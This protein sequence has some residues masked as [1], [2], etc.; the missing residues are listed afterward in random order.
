MGYGRPAVPGK[1]YQLAQGVAATSYEVQ[2]PEGDAQRIFLDAGKNP[3]DGVIVT[4]YLQQKP[5]EEVTLRFLDAQGQPIKAFSSKATN[6]Q[7]SAN[8]P[9][10]PRVPGEAGMNR[11][12]WNMRYADARGVPGDATTERSLT[13]PLARP[14]AYQVQLNVGDQ[15]YTRSFEI[16][17]D[18]RVSAT[19]ADL[20]AQFALLL[21]IRDKLSEAH[22]A[23]NQLRSIRRQVD[24]WVRRTTGQSEAQSAGDAVAHAAKGL[25][26][27]LSGIEEE[28]IQWRAQVP[29][30]QLNYPSRLN[31]K[32]AALTSVVASG[33]G[34]PTRQSY[35]VFR[36]LS[37]RI[38]EQLV[39]LRQVIDTDLLAFNTLIQASKIPA[40][41]PQATP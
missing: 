34:A 25:L 32:L 41:I 23:I 6:E 13:G 2:T 8:A 37:Q 1:N 4:Y 11:F 16:R 20:E 12:V 21:Q 33:D 40:I 9:R 31:A 26:N 10:E 29:Q 24:D 3:P 22:D 17:K 35:E 27:T 30:D 14:G 19:L 38:D 28:L 5:A 18:P 7:R 39:Q 36:D 15:T